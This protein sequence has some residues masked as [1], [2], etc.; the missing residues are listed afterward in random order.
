MR[1]RGR[2]VS[3]CPP[4]CH[5]LGFMIAIRP[6]AAESVKLSHDEVVMVSHQGTRPNL[7]GRADRRR[8]VLEPCPYGR[9]DRQLA[10][11][12]ASTGFGFAG[13]IRL[14]YGA[15]GQPRRCLRLDTATWQRRHPSLRRQMRSLISVSTEPS[16]CAEQH[17]D[18]GRWTGMNARMQMRGIDR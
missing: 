12:A 18:Y 5:W 9:R 8:P 16:T 15:D 1:R 11:Q 14:A 2:H 3:C 17:A 10:L 7:H 13:A 6:Q 4:T